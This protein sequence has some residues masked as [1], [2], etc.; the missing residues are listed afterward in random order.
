MVFLLGPTAS[1][2]SRV[3]LEVARKTGAEIVSLDAFQVYRGMDIGTAKPTRKEQDEIPHHLLDLVNP[4]ESF[5]A[6]NYKREGEGV[7]RALKK[8]GRKAL[9]VG[10]TGLYHRVMTQGLSAAPRTDKEVAE[11]IERMATE[12]MADEIQRVDPEWAKGADLQN[13]RRMVRALAVWQQTGRTMTD[14]QKK[15][16]TPG[17]LLGSRNFVLVPT[18][19]T[20]SRVI[21]QRAKG[22]L[23]GGWVEEVRVLIQR[24]GW[25]GSPG[26]R[27]IGYEQV[28]MMMQGKMGKQ[29]ACDK[30]VT[31]T[32]AY[33][34]RQLTWFR[35]LT[36]FQAIEIDP[37]LSPCKSVVDTLMAALSE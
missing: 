36:N 33:A 26:S 35:G 3:A 19:A 29:E 16:T 32:R 9:W 25:R 21:E 37:Q 6:A 4:E 34:K 20:L 8:D 13:R 1:G 7:V 30:I 5:S 22:M 18:M 14:W 23:E 31:E 15:E 10:G 27:A 28:A 2:K 17:L 11:Q 24:E 12:E